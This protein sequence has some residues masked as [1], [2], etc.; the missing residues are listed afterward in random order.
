MSFCLSV[1]TVSASDETKPQKSLTE[2]IG[3]NTI[4][5]VVVASMDL[6]HQ[7]DIDQVFHIGEIGFNGLGQIAAIYKDKCD[8]ANK[9]IER[10]EHCITCAQQWHLDQED[11]ITNLQKE[12]ARLKN[13]ETVS[14]QQ[15]L[16]ALNQSEISSSSSSSSTTP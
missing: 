2:I 9:D 6:L 15:R 13:K 5:K 4:S 7:R 8:T 14:V 16:V 10:L 11:I 12:I 1:F 3:S